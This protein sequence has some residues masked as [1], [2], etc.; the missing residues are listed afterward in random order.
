MNFSDFTKQN[1]QKSNKTTK[2]MTEED[3]VRTYNNLKD[4]NG[5]QLSKMLFAEVAKQKDEGTFNY[6]SLITSIESIKSLIPQN[7]YE[8]LKKLV[9]SLKW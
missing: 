1:N 7:T 3:I 5:D 9:E 8:N 2:S 4:L 6:Q